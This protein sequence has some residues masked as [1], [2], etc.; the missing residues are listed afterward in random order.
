MKELVK[1]SEK[2]GAAEDHKLVSVD[3]LREWIEDAEHKNKAHKTF[4]DDLMY[5]N[6]ELRPQIERFAEFINY[7]F[8]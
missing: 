2:T 1:L 4:T 5:I 3:S 7:V 8:E 6:L